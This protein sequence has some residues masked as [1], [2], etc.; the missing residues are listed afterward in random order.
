MFYYARGHA[1]SE[2]AP[3]FGSETEPDFG[4]IFCSSGLFLGY[5]GGP[6]LPP[7][8]RGSWRGDLAL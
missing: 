1:D 3:K 4:R 5:A 8:D 6:P 7:L 2:I